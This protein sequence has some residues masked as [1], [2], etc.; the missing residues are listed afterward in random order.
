MLLL[1]PGFNEEEMLPIVVK[2]IAENLRAWILFVIVSAAASVLCTSQMHSQIARGFTQAITLGSGLIFAHGVVFAERRRR[3]L[4][5]LRGLP[6]SES[7]IVGGKFVSV[8]L[9]TYSLAA[10][11][12]LTGLF[13]SLQSP[14][15]LTVLGLSLSTLY[16]SLVLGLYICFRNPALPFIPLYGSTLV[17]L[18]TDADLSQLQ[19]IGPGH[20]ALLSM[21]ASILVYRLTVLVFKMK[22]L[23]F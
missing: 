7:A 14:P 15:S 5:F 18:W 17:I 8:L 21:A 20:A 13:F 11:P 4:V 6:V 10:V 1:Q 9:L 3:H 23:D 22:E 12:Y 16:T 2:D 19:S